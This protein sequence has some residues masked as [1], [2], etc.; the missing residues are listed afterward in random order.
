MSKAGYAYANNHNNLERL[1]EETHVPRPVPKGPVDAGFDTTNP[2]KNFKEPLSKAMIGNR[3][4]ACCTLRYAVDWPT[5]DELFRAPS[6][7]HTQLLALT[8]LF[9][10]LHTAHKD[11]PLSTEQRL[12]ALAAVKTVLEH[13]HF[14]DEALKEKMNKAKL[15]FE[16]YDQA[17]AGNDVRLSIRHSAS[18]AD[19]HEQ[20]HFRAHLAHVV[21]TVAAHTWTAIN[22]TNTDTALKNIPLDRLVEYLAALIDPDVKLVNL[23]VF[24][25]DLCLILSL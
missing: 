1:A 6:V 13:K 5:I 20:A 25:V 12:H 14:T 19:Q 22:N 4:H 16:K 8:A 7:E 21:A 23:F 9:P 10:D 18:N 11:T 3:M 17:D 24:H 2:V 15:F